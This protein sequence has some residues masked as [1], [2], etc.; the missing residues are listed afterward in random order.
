MFQSMTEKNKKLNVLATPAAG[1]IRA[2]SI[3]MVIEDV[4]HVL[5]K[6]CWGLKHSF[7]T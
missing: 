3:G 7:A 2:P 5:M 1:E 6:N 4:K